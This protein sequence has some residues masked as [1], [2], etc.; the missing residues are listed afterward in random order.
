MAI[1]TVTEPEVTPLPM[2]LSVVNPLKK[3][4]T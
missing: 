2:L 4:Q 3:S 1:T